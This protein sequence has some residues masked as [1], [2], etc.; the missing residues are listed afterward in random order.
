MSHILP[1][2]EPIVLDI[3]R[4]LFQDTKMDCKNASFF[5]ISGKHGYRKCEDSV[6]SHAF[7]VDGV[8]YCIMV[9]ADGHGGSEA[10]RTT[11]LCLP[12]IFEANITSM[13][14]NVKDVGERIRQALDTSFRE[15][16]YTLD[17]RAQVGINFSGTTCTCFVTVNESMGLI[18]W[19]GDSEAYV[20]EGTKEV[21]HTKPHIARSVY[22][23]GQPY[24]DM[25][26]EKNCAK[27]DLNDT[28]GHRILE[29]GGGILLDSTNYDHLREFIADSQVKNLPKGKRHHQ[30]SCYEWFCSDLSSTIGNNRCID[31]FALQTTRSLGDLPGTPALRKIFNKVHCRQP[32]FSPILNLT[33]ETVI[34]V[35]SDGVWDVVGDHIPDYMCRVPGC[36]LGFV[37][38]KDVILDKTRALASR[39]DMIISDIKDR[40]KR[41]WFVSSNLDQ[42]D[43]VCGF[44]WSKR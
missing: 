37:R 34:V 18:G 23:C 7:N 15:V 42:M 27:L 22:Q 24:V 20:F 5:S 10:A 41:L 2:Y 38:L 8:N 39:R 9:A 36:D 14:Q 35:G 12:R 28:E 40:Y 31:Y 16:N 21:Y 33:K 32:E 4:I 13:S 25:V 17:S 44:I 29:T 19:V 26:D 30:C 1:V 11:T 3:P 43:D 6:S